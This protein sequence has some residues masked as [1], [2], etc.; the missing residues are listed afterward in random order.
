M[1]MGFMRPR[2]HM[3]GDDLITFAR[4]SRRVSRI[5]RF[6]AGASFAYFPGFIE[7]NQIF[8]MAK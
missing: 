8:R 3:A 1:C 7:E 4:T 5:P 6:N 2:N